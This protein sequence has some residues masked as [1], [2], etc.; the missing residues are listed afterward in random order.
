M[1]NT[2]LFTIAIKNT[3][4][5]EIRLTKEMKD[6]YK[7]SYKTLIKEMVDTNKW[8]TIPCSWIG[9]INIAKMSILPQTLVDSTPSPCQM[10]TVI[11][12]RI[13]KSNPK[14]HMESKQIPTSQSILRRIEEKNITLSPCLSLS[15]SRCVCLY[16]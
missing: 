10:A 3:K 2:I 8:K 13:R 5:L 9:R 15:L 1:K 14:V 12:H 7:E 6:I 16:L 11:F 4:Y